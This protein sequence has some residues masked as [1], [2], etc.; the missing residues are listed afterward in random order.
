MLR[1][2]ANV[3]LAWKLNVQA[4]HAGFDFNGS[5]D[6]N[7]LVSI[8]SVESVSLE[9]NIL[10]AS[11]EELL[12]GAFNG[13]IQIAWLSRGLSQLFNSANLVT[14]II[15]SD[16]EGV[17]SSEEFLEN[18]QGVARETIATTLYLRIFFRCFIFSVLWGHSCLEHF[19]P[20][21]IV[22]VS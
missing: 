19:F 2:E 20:I 3:A 6:F 5:S 7:D 4:A 12:Q 21:A 10:F 9:M 17:V 1:A 18:L 22:N 14:F 13:H 8:G 15:E 11:E 16:S